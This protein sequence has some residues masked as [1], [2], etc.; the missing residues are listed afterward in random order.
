MR[1]S[2]IFISSKPM[3]VGENDPNYRKFFT[4]E[5]GETVFNAACLMDAIAPKCCEKCERRLRIKE[6]EWRLAGGV[7]NF[8]C[9][10]CI[11][12]L[13][14]AGAE[15]EVSPTGHISLK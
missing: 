6:L 3:N 13:V 7:S 2:Q 8:L 12:K 14:K 15:M 9:Y 11:D 10:H 1:D 5:Y 4:K